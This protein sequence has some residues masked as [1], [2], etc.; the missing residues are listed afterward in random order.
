MYMVG[1]TSAVQ[2]ITWLWDIAFWLHC[3]H[4]RTSFFSSLCGYFIDL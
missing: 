4:F 1:K 2:I 3:R